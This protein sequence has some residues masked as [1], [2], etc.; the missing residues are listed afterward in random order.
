MKIFKRKHSRLHPKLGVRRGRGSGFAWLLALVA[1]LLV[2]AALAAR[3]ALGG[4]FWTAAAPLRAVG[5]ATARGAQYLFS[6]F[7][8]VVA[9]KDELAVL[10]V[11]RTQLMAE[12]ADRNLL[13]AE[14]AAL[15]AALGGDSSKHKIR[16][17]VLARPPQLPY[18]T[19]L[20]DAGSARNITAGDIV[21]SGAVALGVIADAAASVSRVRLFSAPGVSTEA[22]LHGTIPVALTG[23]G[24]GSFTAR[25]PQSTNAKPGDAVRLADFEHIVATVERTH[26]ET[27]DTF[28]TVFLAAPVD[29]FEL[30]VI[31]IWSDS[32]L[33]SGTP[34]V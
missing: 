19:L 16:A 18:D 20:I 17:Q 14:N 24:G 8:S 1:I 3:P 33:A 27:G 23:I 6:P 2:G 10:R 7:S 32:S 5:D 31:E 21:G 34:A 28:L 13:A 4:L 12:V 11:E 25:V 26:L 9:L 29:Y 30:P 22:L 15:K